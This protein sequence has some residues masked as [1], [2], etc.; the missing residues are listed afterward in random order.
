MIYTSSGIYKV[1]LSCRISQRVSLKKQGRFFPE[2][3]KEKDTRI[4]VKK[5]L[6]KTAQTQVTLELPRN[7]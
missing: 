1:Y 3:L 4:S 2:L 5:C 7:F 6:E